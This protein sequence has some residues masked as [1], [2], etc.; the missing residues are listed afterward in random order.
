MGMVQDVGCLLLFFKS[1][2]L[3]PD[4]NKNYCSE[5]SSNTLAAKNWFSGFKCEILGKSVML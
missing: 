2:N 5:C 4:I 3:A 1:K